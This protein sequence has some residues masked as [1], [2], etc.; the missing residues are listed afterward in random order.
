MSGLLQHLFRGKRGG[1]AP[2]PMDR[3]YVSEFTNFID[4]FLE[5]HPDV[6]QDQWV[7]REIF[8]DKQVDFADQKH[9]TQDTVPEDGYGFYLSAWHRKAKNTPAGSGAQGPTGG[10]A[11]AS[12][13]LWE[14]TAEHK[15]CGLNC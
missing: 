1:R 5:D 13:S 8:W 12:A 11:S 10:D 14:V 3:A 7:G 2:E 9:A 4:H 6:V 15:R